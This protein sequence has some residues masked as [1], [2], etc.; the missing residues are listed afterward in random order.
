LNPKKL[1]F[2]GL[3][4]A[5]LLGEL[6]NP[7][8]TSAQDTT[9]VKAKTQSPLLERL[10]VRTNAFEWLLTVP[11]VQVAYD[12]FPGPY[13]RSEILGSFKWNWDTWHALPPYYVFN[14]MDL[15]GE[16][17]WHFRF[18]QQK[19][20]EKFKFLSLARP[21]PRPWI[22]H[23]LG[24]YLETGS[25]SLKASLKGSQGAHTGL[26]V[27]Y[28]IELPLYEYGTSAVDIDLG[29]SA[30]VALFN[31]DLYRLNY[32]NTAYA[33][34]EDKPRWLFIPVISEV[35]ATFIWRKNSV[36]TKYTKSDPEIPV[37]NQVMDDIHMEFSGTNKKA[38]DES[39]SKAQ[40]REYSA[41]D[42]LY[43]AAYVEY[44]KYSHDYLMGIVVDTPV[45][46]NR[47]EKL[48]K[49]VT[50]LYNEAIKEF[51]MEIRNRD[52]EAQRAAREAEKA[53]KEAAKED[54]KQKKAEEDE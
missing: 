17:R 47:K 28:G 8:I 14:V 4:L 48:R 7:S 31:Y 41:S 16:Y 3:V 51:D 12:L 18:T 34:L 49:E 37:F 24:A 10:S 36:R 43:R 19:P 39:L 54:A 32:S 29:A 23:Y 26:G 42:S 25:F 2:V 21:N 44:V 9:S 38:F 50:R 53:A 45:N 52:L 46:E 40:Q 5:I 11:N 27:S 22:A 33:A 30:G 1:R 35:R 20:D 13:N 6:F 15:R